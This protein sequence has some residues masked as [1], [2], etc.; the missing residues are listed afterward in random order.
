MNFICTPPVVVPN[1]HLALRI[2]L[3]V[4]RPAGRPR[5]SHLFHEVTVPT[6]FSHRNSSSRLS[7]PLS[8]HPPPPPKNSLLALASVLFHTSPN[9][10]DVPLT[11][12]DADAPCEGGF[13]I[14]VFS[15]YV[16]CAR[17]IVF[18]LYARIVSRGGKERYLCVNHLIVPCISVVRLAKLYNS[19]F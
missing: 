6:A 7:L 14:Q 2:S 5:D 13:E 15:L 8:P 9:L 12:H 19:S 3:S 11:R 1:P 4:G 18:G 10:A 17:T 16:L